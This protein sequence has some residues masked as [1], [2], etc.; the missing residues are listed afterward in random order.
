M[1]KLIIVFEVKRYL[2]YLHQENRLTDVS[3]RI[4]QITRR[5]D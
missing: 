3:I 5:S 4:I 2:I 1:K